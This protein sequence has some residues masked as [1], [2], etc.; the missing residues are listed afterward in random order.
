MRALR[1]PLCRAD[2]AQFFECLLEVANDIEA[3]R[4]RRGEPSLD[5]DTFRA[6]LAPWRGL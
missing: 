3:A 2:F 4:Q 5:F 1:S 6:T